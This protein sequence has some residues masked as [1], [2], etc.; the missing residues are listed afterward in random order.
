[1][2]E[3][4][5]HPS[6]V[7]AWR[8]GRFVVLPDAELEDVTV[9]VAAEADTEGGVKW[10]GLLGRRLSSDRARVCA[11]PFWVHD[12]NLGDEVRLM[13]SAEGAPVVIGVVVD[14]GNY[15]FRVRFASARDE[16]PRWRAL[17]AE[18][19]PFG[20]LADVRSPAFLAIF[21]TAEP[22]ARGG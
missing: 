19:E 14:A 11:I 15:T 20:C 1:M 10:E 22:R 13:E 7:S 18:L 16:D 2:V 4:D 9:W 8:D 21:G 3:F 6:K 5:E 12:L 17:M